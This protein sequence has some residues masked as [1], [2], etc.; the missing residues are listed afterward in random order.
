MS[1]PDIIAMKLN[2]ITTSGQRIKDFVDIY[3]L[4]DKYDL[5]TMLGFYLKKYDQQNDLL[6]LKSLICFEDIEESEW[7]ILI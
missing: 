2:A 6:I 4:L 5:K 7:P 3:Y 1:E